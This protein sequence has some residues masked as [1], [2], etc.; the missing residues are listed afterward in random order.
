MIN[1]Y[2]LEKL[3]YSYDSL[4]PFIDTHTLGLHHLKHEKKYLDKLNELLIRNNYNYEYSI[5]ELNYHLNEFSK[6]SREEI[7][8]NLGGVINHYIYFNSMSPNKEEPNIFLKNKINERFGS[9]SEFKK[10]FK[11]SALKLQGSGY[12]FLVLDNGKLKIINL[13][14]QANPYCFGYIPLIGID[15]WEH[16]Y[17]LN[18]ENKKEIYIDNF[19]EIMDFKRANQLF[20]K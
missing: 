16:A 15:M 18:Y 5:V 1:L 4:E 12:T 20:E 6:E 9:I 11:E 8:F 14:N 7:L 3:P 2:K 13:K 17:Y 19:L 10:R